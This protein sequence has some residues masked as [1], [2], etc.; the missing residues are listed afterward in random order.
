MVCQ[1]I[2]CPKSFIKGAFNC[3]ARDNKIFRN[4]PVFYRFRFN[5]LQ[6]F[7]RRKRSR[8]STP[9][10]A[11]RK[12]VVERRL[13]ISVWNYQERREAAE[14]SRGLDKESKPPLTPPQE[15]KRDAGLKTSALNEESNKPLSNPPLKGG[16]KGRSHYK[17]EQPEIISRIIN[18]TRP[19]TSGT[20]N[21]EKSPHT[22]RGKWKTSP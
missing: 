4:N 18:K 9:V 16:N 3:L 14:Y 8:G 21:I 13:I 7:C 12:G 5:C 11:M 22:M 20:M 10:W 17:K 1:P 2:E 15:G 19:M 6:Y